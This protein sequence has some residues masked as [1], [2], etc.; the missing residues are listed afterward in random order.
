ML[1]RSRFS[2]W[3]VWGSLLMSVWLSDRW[4][5]M[6]PGLAGAILGV[7]I[8]KRGRKDFQKHHGG[9]PAGELGA[10]LIIG[11]FV[12]L[13]LLFL[14]FKLAR[15]ERPSVATL[16]LGL[17]V[18]LLMVLGSTAVVIGKAKIPG[19]LSRIWDKLLEEH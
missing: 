1:S 6:I 19:W 18:S 15:A 8:S 4:I 10:L 7:A 5:W 2:R 16:F 3:L 11:S 9:L 13:Y 14:V 17:I 12:Y